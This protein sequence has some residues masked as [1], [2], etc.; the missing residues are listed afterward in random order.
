M[1]TIVRFLGWAWLLG[2]LMALGS[3]LI[4]RYGSAMPLPGGLAPALSLPWSQ[5]VPM[6]GVGP[7]LA[8]AVMGIG[9]FVNAQILFVIANILER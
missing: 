4:G 9:V 6:L 2:G 8:M 1:S 7:G 5:L 3:L